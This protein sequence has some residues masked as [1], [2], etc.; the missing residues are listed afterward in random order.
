MVVCI[1]EGYATAASIHE[2]TG[3]PV[4]V[5]FNAGNLAAVTRALRQTYPHARLIVCADDDFETPGNPGLALASAAARQSS[6]RVSVPTFGAGRLAGET[7]FND[8]HRTQG[9]DAVRAA[10]DAAAHPPDEHL[11]RV[12]ALRDPVTE[13]PEPA[14][15]GEPLEATPYPDDALPGILGDAVRQAQTFVQAPMALVACSALSTLSVAVQGLVNVWRDHHLAGPVSLYLLALADS[16]ERKTTCDAGRVAIARHSHPRSKNPKPRSLHLRPR[17]PG[18]LGAR[19]CLGH[20]FGPRPACSRPRPA[21]YLAPTAWDRI[22]CFE[23]WP[24]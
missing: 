12:F 21:Q 15:L 19:P 10:L 18:S 1:A 7:D 8:L 24:C 23:I 13:W 6:A 16:G 4:V 5:A 14:P 20:R 3:H 17:R 22:L 9:L 11:D 2:A